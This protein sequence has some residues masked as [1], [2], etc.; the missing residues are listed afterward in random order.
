MK[1]NGP[2]IA[3]TALILAYVALSALYSMATALQTGPDE[4]AHFIYVRE[5]ATHFHIPQ[6]AHD[7]NINLNGKASYE[8]HQPPL[9]YTLACIPYWLASALKSDQDGT[10][11]YI[12]IFTV[13]FGAAW[14]FFLYKLACEFFGER[15]YSAI[16]SAAFL[17]LLPLSV[18]MGG[19][20]NNDIPAAMLFTAALWLIMRSLR[21]RRIQQQDAVWIGIA[22]G[23]ALLT[24]AQAIF[25]LPTLLA[26]AIMIMA[27]SR[28]KNW[29]PMVLN[30]GL[31]ILIALAISSPWFI[32]NMIVFG[33]PSVQSLHH[34]GPGWSWMWVSIVLTQMFNHFW[35]PYWIVGRFV[36]NMA[37]TRFLLAF[38]V[39]VA[40]SMI[41]FLALK[42]TDKT[43]RLQHSI[44]AWV[45]LKLPLALIIISL[46]HRTLTVDLGLLQGG[47]LLLPGA[48][49]LG[50]SV[51]AGPGSFIQAR[52]TR[53]IAGA[54]LILA[55]L[56]ADILVFRTFGSYYGYL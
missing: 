43:D 51:V 11:E 24:K 54:L 34:P 15:S 42:S 39:L 22:G 29:K 23:L 47:R 6:I 40:I 25:L 8:A 38:V 16:L 3:L 32:R 12:R 20:I 13:L 35:T 2:A 26:A 27:Q 41:R 17:G 30:S 55:L 33:T 37:Y 53:I 48:G 7:T 19:V 21:Q 49:I 45:I 56:L 36:D 9:Y 5:M 28:W 10:W 44:A 18:Y 46:L 4:S 52:S 31:A 50:M 14:I 1:R